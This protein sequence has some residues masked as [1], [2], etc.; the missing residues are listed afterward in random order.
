MR[1]W[2]AVLAG[3]ALGVNNTLITETVMKV[4]PVERGVASAAY[5]F[6]RFSGGAVAPWL[7]GTLGERSAHLPFFVGAG[8]VVTSIRSRVASRRTGS[9]PHSGFL[10]RLWFGLLR[11]LRTRLLLRR[12]NLRVGGF[13]DHIRIVDRLLVG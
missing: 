1:L 12:N 10:A 3:A 7:A 9:L 6:V 8:A 11:V 4:A 13:L 2:A 5:S